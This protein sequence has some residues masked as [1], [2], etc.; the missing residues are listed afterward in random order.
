MKNINKKFSVLAMGAG[1][2]LAGFSGVANAAS[3]CC[4]QLCSRYPD[5]FLNECLMLCRD[6]SFYSCI[7]L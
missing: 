5:G 4:M 2:G 7:L 3:Q 6:T 1:V